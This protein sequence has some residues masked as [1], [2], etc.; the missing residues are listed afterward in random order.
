MKVLHLTCGLLLFVHVACSSSAAHTPPVNIYKSDGI[1]IEAGFAPDETRIILGQPL[2]ITFKVTNQADKPYGF[3]VGGDDRGSVRHNNFKITAVDAQGNPVKDPYSYNHFG[4]HGQNVML[5][6]DQSYRERLFLGHWC[7]FD[8]PGRYTLTCTRELSELKGSGEEPR[9]ESLRITS[10]FDLDIGPPDAEQMGNVITGL[11]QKLREGGKENVYEATLA[12]ASIA[13]ERVVPHL[14]RSLSE[15]DYQNKLPAVQGLAQFSS[16]AA[17]DALIMALKDPDHV[18]RDA[19]G[20]ALKGKKIDRALHTLIP[21]MADEQASTRAMAARALGATKDR[22]A[23]DVLVKATLDREDSVRYAAANALGSLG[24]K[25][26]REPLIRLVEGNDM[27][28]R[29]AAAQGL[30]A[31]GEP[32]QA[33]WL[34]PVIGSVTDVNNQ[35]FHEAIRL[36]RLYGRDNAAPALVSCLNFD[37]PSPRNSRNMFLILAIHYSLNGPQY[38]YKFY[39]DPNTDGTPEKIAE[40]RRILEELRKWLEDRR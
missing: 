23:F 30:V 38:Y 9:N 22:K 40:N 3:F 11:G 8:K 19:A 7:A 17:A 13:D 6:R 32:L 24:Q 25:D 35:D 15:G 18:V 2:F 28:M 14:A 29:V 10:D 36:I 34:T 27:G 12:L 31:L 16:D 1:V 26:A 21:D 33:E 20:N 39:S 4:G 5:E 37:D